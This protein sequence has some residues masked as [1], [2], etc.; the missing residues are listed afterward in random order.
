MSKQPTIGSLFQ[1]FLRLGLTAF[2]GPV[3]I[4]Y[5][6]EL[7]V[8][9]KGWLDEKSFNDGIVLC[10]SLPGA[11]VMQMAAYVGLRTRGIMGALVSYIGFGLPAFI[12]MLLLS[13]LY[14]GSHD[15]SWIESIFNGLQVIVVAIVAY[16][17]Y[18]FSKTGIKDYVTALFAAVSAILFW[19]GVSPFLVIIGAGSAGAFFFRNAGDVSA[20]VSH[21]RE[22]GWTYRQI[23]TLCVILLGGLV[24]FYFADEELFRLAVLMLRIDLFAFGGGFASVPLMLHEIV[25]VRGWMDSKTFMDGIALGQVTPGPIVITAT[26]VGYLLYGLVG[27][28]VATIAMFAPSFLLLTVTAP[29]FDKLKASRY[30]SGVTK[31]ILASFVGL[32][33]FVTV[34]FAL[35]VP[36]DIMKAIFGFTALTAL[37]MKVD[38]LHVVLIGAAIS[39]VIL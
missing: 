10:Q 34:K 12:L 6:K 20:P 23:V 38:I 32:L 19:K 33:L 31:G 16:A 27:S 8:K 1:S 13:I 22:T 15:I 17:V 26:F 7:S 18:T 30:F 25:D 24:G 3:M 29:V 11:T 4:A 35:A 14:A 2:G 21:M 36:W 37:F 39:L 5:V 9:R 28:L